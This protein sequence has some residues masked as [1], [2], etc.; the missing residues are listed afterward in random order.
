MKIF[1]SLFLLAFSLGCFS[2]S[3][4][5]LVNSDTPRVFGPGII[6]DGFSNR[7]MALSPDGNDLYYTLQWSYGLFSV[8]L[9]SE[10]I[11]G[12]W[13]KPETAWFSGR[14]NDLEPAFSPDGQKL[15][16][17]SSRPLQSGDS[18]KDYDI[19]YV[20][21]KGGSWDGPFNA[22]TA[23]NT[24]NDE[25]Y[26]SLAK[27]GNMYFTRDN[28]DTKDDIFMA[29]FKNGKYEEPVRLPDAVNS[30]GYDFNAFVD[31]DENFIIFSSYKR[32]DD[33]GGGDLYYSLRGNG[34]WQPALHFGKEINSAALDYSPFVSGDKRYFF[35]SSKRI[36][37]KFPFTEP[38]TAAQIRE[39]LGSYGN[40]NDDIYIMNFKVL[41][42]L[43]K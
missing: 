8:I 30:K 42:K 24:T 39:V 10:K 4:I 19:W 20:Q 7:D 32:V 26:P 28:G 25:F 41:E 13:A 18:V 37:L 31:P 3:R 6:S 11:N 23:I 29:A 5:E 40:G 1:L 15:F 43:M 14:F 17:T 16:F 9:H 34:N 33:I 27:N 35:F 12:V 2:Q 36:L 38:R 21:R 22:G